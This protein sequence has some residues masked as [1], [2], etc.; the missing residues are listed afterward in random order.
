MSKFDACLTRLNLRDSVPVDALRTT[1]AEYEA[2]GMDPAA[3]MLRAV[4]DQLE[5]AQMEEANI[6][7]TVRSKYEAAGGKKKPEQK[8]QAQRGRQYP[9]TNSS[10]A[11]S[12]E[13]RAQ[14]SRRAKEAERQAARRRARQAD[15]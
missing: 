1:A 13:A 11:R 3:A 15:G 12:G 5:L 8:A 10:R 14:E 9:G 7:N 4:E 2:E 6:I